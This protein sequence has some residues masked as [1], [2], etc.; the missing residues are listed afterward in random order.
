M[1]SRIFAALGWL[2]VGCGAGEPSLFTGTFTEAELNTVTIAPERGAAVT[3]ST[4]GAELIGFEE[5]IPGSPVRV[6]YT[7]RI[8]KG[9]EVPALRIEV[10]PTYARLLGRWIETGEG[11]D[12]L[13]MGFEL[14][15]RGKKNEPNASSIGMQ[16]LVFRRWE[17][18]PEGGLLL[19]GHSLGNGNTVSFSEEWEILLLDSDRLVIAQPDL[20]L[21]LR[22]ETE[23]DVVRRLEREEQ[24]IRGEASK[25]SKKRK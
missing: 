9:E 25:S 13:G 10:D 24:A 1:R 17:L 11:A 14:A 21:T 19:S 12:E 20:T 23:E 7:G 4:E 5:L 18:T 3:F 15:P 22:R 6:T 8:D 2:F 16:T